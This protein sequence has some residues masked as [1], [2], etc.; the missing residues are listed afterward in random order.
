[1]SAVGQAPRPSPSGAAA[2]RFGGRVPLAAWPPLRTAFGATLALVGVTCLAVG[3]ATPGLAAPGG[4]AG[5][6]LLDQTG[7]AS[8]VALVVVILGGPVATVLGGALGAGAL[9]AGAL[10]R[11]GDRANGPASRAEARQLRSFAALALLLLPGVA[12]VTAA[13]LVALAIGSWLA[14]DVP[15]RPVLE[16]DPVAADTVLAAI[17]RAWA[18]GVAL[19]ALGFAAGALTGRRTAG[20]AVIGGLV[21]AELLVG[22]VDPASPLLAVAPLARLG[23]HARAGSVGEAVPALVIVGGAAALLAGV[24]V[25]GARLR[26]ADHPEG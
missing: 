17:I 24:A 6:P 13:G 18:A 12:V 20:L 5:G 9:G 4:G 23:D 1:M 2:G 26:Q 14:G 11:A 25:L 21:A 7:P 15:G 19:A 8:I 10:A 22:V 16:I 3:A